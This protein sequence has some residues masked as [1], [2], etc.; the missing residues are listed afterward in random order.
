MRTGGY[1]VCREMTIGHS[2][3]LRSIRPQIEGFNLN[4]WLRTGAIRPKVFLQVLRGVELK[5]NVGN[6]LEPGEIQALKHAMRQ[7]RPDLHGLLA[8]YQGQAPVHLR[9]GIAELVDQERGK[10]AQHDSL[11]ILLSASRAAS[12]EG[13]GAALCR[14]RNT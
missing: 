11:T 2:R 1:R 3:I 10:I 7:A 5:T 8:R 14:S 9:L 12:K 4:W 6:H 13:A